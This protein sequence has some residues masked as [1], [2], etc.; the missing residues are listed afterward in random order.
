M[1][2]AETRRVPT[3]RKR[4]L[5]ACV[6]GTFVALTALVQPA[7]AGM[8]CGSRLVSEGDHKIEVLSKCG[9]P[10]LVEPLG[11]GHYTVWPHYA[12]RHYTAYAL[13]EEWTYNFGPRR[14]MRLVRFADGKVIRIISLDYGY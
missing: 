14:F 9:E 7:Q 6:I 2:S 12:H 13:I 1:Q 10:A 5:L 8:R 11:Y 4:L 3:L